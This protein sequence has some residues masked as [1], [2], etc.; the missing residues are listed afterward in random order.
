MT[1]E[2]FFLQLSS[3]HKKWLFTR[4]KRKESKEIWLHV[5]FSGSKCQVWMRK[6]WKQHQRWADLTRPPHRCWLVSA[7]RIWGLTR[8]WLVSAG[9]SRWPGAMFSSFFCLSSSRADAH[10]LPPRNRSPCTLWGAL[11]PS[12]CEWVSGYG[13]MSCRRCSWFFLLH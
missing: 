8:R 6:V 3:A 4:A 9:V 11:R 1:A 2:L 12:D 10:A 13:S 7:Q 5:L